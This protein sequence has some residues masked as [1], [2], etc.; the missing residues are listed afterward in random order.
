MY[1]RVVRW[2]LRIGDDWSGGGGDDASSCGLI[3]N[4]ISHSTAGCGALRL[5]LLF[6][7]N[8]LRALRGRDDDCVLCFS[9]PVAPNLG[10]PRTGI[11]SHLTHSLVLC[12]GYFD[13]TCKISTHFR[14]SVTWIFLHKH[15]AA[16]TR[17]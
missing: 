1:V 3:I 16:R 5:M 10:R 14:P 15:T 12:S 9:E 8:L 11:C 7:Y 2:M 17:L 4:Q 6:F 13:S